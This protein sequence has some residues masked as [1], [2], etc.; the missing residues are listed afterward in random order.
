MIE[1]PSSKMARLLCA[2]PGEDSQLTSIEFPLQWKDLGIATEP[3]MLTIRGGL[4]ALVY[5]S[6][7][8]SWKAL[9]SI[10]VNMICSIAVLILGETELIVNVGSAALDYMQIS[11]SG[12]EYRGRID[13]K[14]LGEMRVLRQAA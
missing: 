6:V 10:G 4:Y 5:S 7:T 3:P 1:L 9:Q 2:P 14:L 12:D 11:V 13:L 8:G